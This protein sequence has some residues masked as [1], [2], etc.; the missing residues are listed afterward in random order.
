MSG[1]I[2]DKPARPPS[3]FFTPVPGWS[4]LEILSQVQLIHMWAYLGSPCN[5]PETSQVLGSPPSERKGG[6]CSRMVG[7]SQGKPAW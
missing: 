4:R 7:S 6:V 3:P 5:S 1:E 2:V